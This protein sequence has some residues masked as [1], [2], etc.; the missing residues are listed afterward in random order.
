MKYKDSKMQSYIIILDLS[1]TF[2]IV[3]H[4]KVLYKLKHYARYI[5]L[6]ICIPKIKV[7]E[8]SCAWQT[9]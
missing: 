9:F 4:N 2:D 5:R 3:P 8:C 7:T 6:D 1:K